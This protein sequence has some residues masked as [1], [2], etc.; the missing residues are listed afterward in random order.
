MWNTMRA[1]EQCD[2]SELCYEHSL[3][4]LIHSL[5]NLLTIGQKL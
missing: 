2:G 3:P 1:I 5:A 4:A